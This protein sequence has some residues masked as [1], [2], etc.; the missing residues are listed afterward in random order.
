[1]ARHAP[2][3]N[4]KR[5]SSLVIRSVDVTTFGKK[6]AARFTVPGQ[7]SEMQC[8]LAERVGAVDVGA[9]LQQNLSDP[10]VP[11]CPP[12]SGKINLA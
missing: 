1:M 12:L 8:G 3:C 6:I 11:C 10:L 2:A 7:G 4:L 5:S 9:G